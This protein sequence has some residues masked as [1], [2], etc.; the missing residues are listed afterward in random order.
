MPKAGNSNTHERI[1]LMQRLLSVVDV[2]DTQGF[3]ADREF[4]ERDWF[5]Y[6]QRR[7]TPFHIRVRQDALCDGW[8]NAFIFFQHLP[9][10]QSRC[11]HHRYPIFGHPLAVTGMRLA[12][13]YL[14]IVTNT[15]PKQSLTHYAL[16]WRIGSFF[17]AIETTGFD[18]ETSE[19]T[20]HRASTSS[21]SVW[22]I[23]V[24]HAAH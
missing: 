8:F 11:L 24:R 4:V 12:D 16:R 6:L 9:E 15:N 5:A 23:T 7:R 19:M 20:S 17:A 13:D 21:P 10:G 3:L 22:T 18:M 2:K 14:I 1:E